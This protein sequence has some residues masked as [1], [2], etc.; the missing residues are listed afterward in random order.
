MCYTATNRQAI[1]Q[2]AMVLNEE[3]RT[4]PGAPRAE[5]IDDLPTTY[6]SPGENRYPSR[7]LK[8]EELV[9]WDMQFGVTVGPIGFDHRLRCP[10]CDR[11]LLL[12]F[13]EGGRDRSGIRIAYTCESCGAHSVV[14]FTPPGHKL[15]LPP[16]TYGERLVIA[17]PTPVPPDPKEAS[18]KAPPRRE[19]QQ[20]Q[21]QERTPS[22]TA[23]NSGADTPTG[24]KRSQGRQ[25]QGGTRHERNE[26]RQENSG[27][28]PRQN[29]Q[30]RQRQN[31]ASEG[32]KETSP[33]RQDRPERPQRPANTPAAEAAEA[34]VARAPRAQDTNVISESVQD[35]ADRASSKPPYQHQRRRRRPYRPPTS[36]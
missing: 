8:I 36:Q 1:I 15:E 21:R 34:P 3:T 5:S 28:A 17:Q 23:P 6:D 20:S 25:Q 26:E 32:A 27:G 9:E 12:S 31:P 24:S 16:V 33:R 10:Y 29:R 11:R 35:Q 30:Q 14:S 4:P 19:R 18:G 13:H 22:S 7:M 2:G